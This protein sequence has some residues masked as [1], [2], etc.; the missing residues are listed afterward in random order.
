MMNVG[1]AWRAR[2]GLIA[3]SSGH[4]M[5][6]DFHRFAPPGVGIATT[7]VS[8]R[9]C[10]RETLMEMA[11]KLSGAAEIYNDRPQDVVTFGCTSGS[12]IGGVGFDQMLIDRIEKS[13]GCKGLTTSTS[14]MDALRI[15]GINRLAVVTP[16]IEEVNIAEHDFLVSQ[17]IEVTS[18]EGL[19]LGLPKQVP[20]IVEL[21]PNEMYTLVKKQ[22]LSNADAVFVSCT[23]LNVL[24][25]IPYV[26]TDFGLPCL[27]SNQV[28]LW[29]ALRACGVNDKLP[30][31]GTL[32]NQY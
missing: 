16:Y 20:G 9:A 10:N 29:G 12:F 23:G 8:L 19:G 24:D 11:E 1:Y 3:P 25:I 32:C 14:L 26:E 4:N 7:R 22:D 15:M 5:E 28:T 21:P 17:G 31:L 2:I 18:I 30:N 13:A 6:H 27:T